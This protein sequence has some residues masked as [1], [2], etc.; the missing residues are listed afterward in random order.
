[1][2][3]LRRIS[4]NGI[5]M[6]FDLGNSYTLIDKEKNPNDFKMH[7]DH[8][9]GVDAKTYAFIAC[10]SGSIVYQLYD[11]QLN[12]IMTEGGKTFSNLTRSYGN[13]DNENQKEEEAQDSDELEEIS[14]KKIDEG[15]TPAQTIIDN[16]N[17]K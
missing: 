2:F 16:V 1:M 13:P 14:R 8:I 4:G 3:Y 15:L 11:G 12:Y 17:K 10:H 7:E 6:N 5:E 9:G